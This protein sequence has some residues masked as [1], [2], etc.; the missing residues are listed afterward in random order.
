M[1]SQNTTLQEI[2]QVQQTNIIQ[3]HAFEAPGI[4]KVI[5]VKCKSNQVWRK[6]INDEEGEFLCNSNRGYLILMPVHDNV[7]VIH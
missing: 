4:G 7:I 2:S 3:S 1:S 6:M 5:E